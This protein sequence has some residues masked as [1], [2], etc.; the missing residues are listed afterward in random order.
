MILTAVVVDLKVPRD[1]RDRLVHPALMETTAI[2]SLFPGPQDHLV[3]RAPRVLR[4]HKARL[5]PLALLV[6]QGLQGP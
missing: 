5:V 4:D 2:P 1:H 3:H 6:L